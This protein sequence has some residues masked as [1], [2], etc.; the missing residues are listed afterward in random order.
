MA[1][2]HTPEFV[3]AFQCKAGSKMNAEKKCEVF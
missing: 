2:A 3:E 1:L